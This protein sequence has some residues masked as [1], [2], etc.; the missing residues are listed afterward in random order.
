MLRAMP[1]EFPKLD[2]EQVTDGLAK[3]REKFGENNV[4]LIEWKPE[5]MWIGGTTPSPPKPFKC[6]ITLTSAVTGQHFSLGKVTAFGNTQ[7][8][9]VQEAL[10][11]TEAITMF[12]R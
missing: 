7:L 11:L 6:R 9:A 4:E 10:R 1:L 12:D 8:E 5:P 3:L 2:K